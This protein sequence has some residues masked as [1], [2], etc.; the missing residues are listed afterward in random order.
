MNTPSLQQH[1]AVAPDGQDKGNNRVVERTESSPTMQS[2][3]PVSDFTNQFP[4]RLHRMLKEVKKE[5]LDSII[6]WLPG[7]EQNTFKVHKKDEF[8][9]HIMPRYFNQTK[10]KSFLR[11]LNLWGFDRILDSGPMRGSYRHPLF[12]KDKP[13]LC[14]QMKRTKVKG[15]KQ[16]EESESTM[17]P[18]QLT[19]S[20]SNTNNILRP[21]PQ[22]LQCLFRGQVHDNSNTS[23]ESIEYERIP[24]NLPV[25]AELSRMYAEDTKYGALFNMRQRD[26]QQGPMNLFHA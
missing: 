6:S 16:K 26:H 17:L 3:L 12:V 18:T 15:L 13:E 21:L 25:A 8:V 14:H 10:Y 20:L 2:A 5:N 11:Q 23:L 7:G 24:R 4:W 22:T 9:E 1:H 19:A